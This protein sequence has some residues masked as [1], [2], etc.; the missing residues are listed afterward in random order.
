MAAGLVEL[1]EE[2]ISRNGLVLRGDAV[3]L[4]LSAGKDSMALY[5]IMRV[6]APQLGVTLAVFHLNHGVRGA[7]SDADEAFLKE[8]CARDNI[9]AV[10][11]RHDFSQQSAAFEERAR[12]VRYGLIE[13]A[14]KELGCTFAATAHTAS[15]Q[16]ETVLMRACTGTHIRGLEGIPPK[17]GNIIRPL[18]FASS[19]DIYAYLNAEKIAWREDE[20]NADTGYA[21]NFLRHEIL[22]KL[23]ERFENAS[24]N[25]A[26]ISDAAAESRRM[27]LF[28]L[29]ELGMKIEHKNKESS[30]QITA[31]LDSREVFGFC[32]AE[33]VAAVG[34]YLSRERIDEAFRRFHSEKA[35]LAVYDGGDIIVERTRD[36][37]TLIAKCRE[38]KPEAWSVDI[39]T[40][41]LPQSY[42]IGE[43]S[44]TVEIT[45]FDSCASGLKRRDALF[46]SLD[47][48]ESQIIVRSKCGGD[49]VR[50]DG[51]TRKLKDLFIGAKLSAR[52]KTS[53]PVVVIGGS[54][55]AAGI[56]FVSEYA[57]RISDDRTVHVGSKKILAIY[58]TRPNI[59]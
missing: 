56:G 48:T 36:R 5:H 59:E 22:P 50:S 43:L 20:S 47:G 52:Q 57:N 35:E 26:A 18:L 19:E 4:S 51:M 10:F 15:D 54:I 40:S 32:I 42:N 55:A 30:L 25:I 1:T 23:S 21:R 53:V 39:D 8:L 2:F 28:L 17:R 41:R 14:M 44:F 13:K 24:R 49:S 29:S 27:T 46:L 16:A 33:L 38:K 31:Q 11:R 3:L 12:D 7:E 6:L 34:G 37:K 45:D 9:P 58:R